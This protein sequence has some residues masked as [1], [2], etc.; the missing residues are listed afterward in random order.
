M[1]RLLFE[2]VAFALEDI[3]ALS[4]LRG[5]K[6]QSQYKRKPLHLIIIIPLILIINYNPI[7][8]Y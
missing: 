3:L 7:C 1:V 2:L 5:A 4:K 8:T 6:E